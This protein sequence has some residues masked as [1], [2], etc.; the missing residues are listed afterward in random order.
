MSSV[1]EHANPVVDEDD[2]VDLG[3]DE[4]EDGI[5][6]DAEKGGGDGGGHTR[7]VMTR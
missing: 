5:D 2:E 4:G 7:Q 6:L 1:R 3:Y